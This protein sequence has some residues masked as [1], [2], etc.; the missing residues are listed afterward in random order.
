MAGT[1]V[2]LASFPPTAILPAFRLLFPALGVAF[3]SLLAGA[4]VLLAGGL[5]TPL[6]VF[7]S[8][9]DLWW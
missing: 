2:P 8:F 9:V 5:L 3:L 6:V 4:P 7:S 1:S